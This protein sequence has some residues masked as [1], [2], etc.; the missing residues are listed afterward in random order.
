MKSEITS[1][2]PFIGAKDYAVSRAFYREL[3][4]TE[5]VIDG[6]LSVFHKDKIS[7]YLQDY[8]HKDWIENTMLFLEVTDVQEQYQ[9][10]KDAKLDEKYPGV[11]LMAIKKETW[12]EECFL[13]DPAG[14]LLHFG[15]FY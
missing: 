15:L 4:F 8:Y 7:F 12:G 3:G 9:F 5:N 10:L 14:V 1:I 11:R 2:R 13:I 6:K